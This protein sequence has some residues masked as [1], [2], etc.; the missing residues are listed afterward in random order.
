MRYV[1]SVIIVSFLSLAF[2]SHSQASIVLFD[3]GFNVDGDVTSA[4]DGDTLPTNNFINDLGEI[5][6]EVSGAGSHF[7][8]AFFDYEIDQANNTFFNESALAVGTPEAELSW[9]ID[10]PGQVFGDIFDNLLAGVF[11]NS[12]ALASTGPEDVSFGLGWDFTLTDLQSAVVT[13]SLSDL[14]PSSGF[15][16]RHFDDEVGPAFDQTSNVYFSSA[17]S[18]TTTPVGPPNQVDAPGG[19]G[20][21]LMSILAVVVQRRRSR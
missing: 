5:T 2:S 17:L 21:F 6:I 4:T 7:I 8:Y 16:L 11:D 10:E 3:W 13:F 15:Y 9:E 18:I 20:L 14:L 19:M 1:V 12:N